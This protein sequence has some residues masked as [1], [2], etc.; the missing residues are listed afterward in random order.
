MEDWLKCQ[1]NPLVKYRQN[2]KTYLE[3]PFSLSNTNKVILTKMLQLT[4][5][6]LLWFWIYN[7]GILSRGVNAK[8]FLIY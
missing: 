3:S 6:V 1:I 5:T 4:D 7:V 8:W 2:Q